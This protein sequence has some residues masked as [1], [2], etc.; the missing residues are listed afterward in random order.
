L[1]ADAGVFDAGD[2][3]VAPGAAEAGHRGAPAFDFDVESLA[4]GESVTRVT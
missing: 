1:E 4:A 3:A 2:D